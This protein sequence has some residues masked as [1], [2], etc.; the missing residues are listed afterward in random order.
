MSLMR[1]LACRL[2]VF[3]ATM[4]MVACTK[5]EDKRAPAPVI[6]DSVAEITSFGINGMEPNV[7]LLPY[8]VNLRFADSIV[9]ARDLVATFTLTPG[10]EATVNGFKQVSD[11]TKN[12]FESPFY[13]TITNTQGF[14]KRW[15]VTATNNDYTAAWGLGNFV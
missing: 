11:V 7:S 15:T 12:N 8:A 5:P 6:T 10:A 3:L 14:V 4:A 2:F 13:Y 9:N 1:S